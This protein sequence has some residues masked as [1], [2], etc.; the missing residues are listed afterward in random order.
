MCTVDSSSVNSKQ[1]HKTAWCMRS[2]TKYTLII[3]TVDERQLSSLIITQYSLSTTMVIILWKLLMFYQIFLS[4]QGKRSLIISNQLVCTCYLRV[5]EQLKTSDLRKLGK[6]KLHNIKI[7][8]K[9]NVVS[10]LPPKKKILLIL[11]KDSLKIE[12]ELFQ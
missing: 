1:S 11:A 7:W 8:W 2:P 4:P 5:V 3:N 10:S 6:L 12:I 9:Y